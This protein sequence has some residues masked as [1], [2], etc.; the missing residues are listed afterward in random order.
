M[1]KSLEIKLGKR[2]QKRLKNTKIEYQFNQIPLMPTIVI[3]Y[4]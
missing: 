2:V 4:F 1:K 3:G